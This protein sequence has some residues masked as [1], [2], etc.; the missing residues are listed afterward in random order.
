MNYSKKLMNVNGRQL[1]AFLEICRLQ[2]FARAAELIHISPSGLSMLVKE[3]EEQ[4]GARL[5]DRTTRSIAMT[6]AARRLQ[7]VAERIVDDLGNIGTSIQG[8]ESAM[9][10][11]LDIA[12]TPMISASVLPPVIR[13]FA[14]SYPDV[15]IHLSDVDVAAVRSRVL[16]A[17]ADIGLGFFV[18][19]AA[20]LLREP[21]S[22]FRLMHIAPPGSGPVGLGKSRPWTDLAGLPL[23]SLPKENP[24]QAL[25][26][27]HLARIGRAHEN[28]SVVNLLGTLIGMVAAGIGH[29][30]VPSF[31]LGECLRHGL[32][33]AMLVNPAVHLDLFLISRRGAANKRA[34]VHFAGA[35]KLAAS[36]V[37]RV[38]S[39]QAL[40]Q[41]ANLV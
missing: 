20:G 37:D 30:V 18:K 2:S 24:I 4:V 22:S 33:V 17:E 11:R 31:V 21:L 25:I 34:A 38:S 19:P 14:V 36:R 27:V 5:F 40:S 26:E 6:D 1:H 15:R 7:P 39:S 32:N 8:A 12:A 13:G 16:G 41:S 28:R 10:A 35:L 9:H 29:A 3:L 23:V